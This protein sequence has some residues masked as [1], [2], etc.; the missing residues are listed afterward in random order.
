MMFCDRNSREASAVVFIA[1]VVAVVVA[2]VVVV[3]VAVV[4]AAD[5]E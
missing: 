2:V 5:I 3:V 4:N 1:I